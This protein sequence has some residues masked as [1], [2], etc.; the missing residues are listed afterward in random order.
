MVRGTIIRGIGSA[1]GGGA[2]LRAEENKISP[3]HRFVPIG[4]A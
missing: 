1:G 4:Q 3:S 2:D